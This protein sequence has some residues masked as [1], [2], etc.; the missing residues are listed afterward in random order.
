[1]KFSVVLENAEEGGYTASVPALD[2]C[3]TQGEIELTI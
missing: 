2:G 1:M 3:F